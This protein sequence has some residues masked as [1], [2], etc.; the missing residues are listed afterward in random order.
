MTTRLELM[1]ELASRGDGSLTDYLNEE[2]DANDTLPAQKVVSGTPAYVNDTIVDYQ[3]Q[4][5]D[6][7]LAQ[8]DEYK[9]IVVQLERDNGELRRKAELLLAESD[10]YVEKLNRIWEVLD[11]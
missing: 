1:H 5:I 11:A 7:L 4:R 2:V 6:V 10:Y 9:A 3:Q 8:R